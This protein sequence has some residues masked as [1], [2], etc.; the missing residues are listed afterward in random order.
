MQD[1]KDTKPKKTQRWT[2]AHPS[3]LPIQ[4]MNLLQTFFV[5]F[6]FKYLEFFLKRIKTFLLLILKKRRRWTHTGSHRPRVSGCRMETL[7]CCIVRSLGTYRLGESLPSGRT[8]KHR[9][10]WN[11]TFCE[12]PH[13]RTSPA[14][15]QFLSSRYKAVVS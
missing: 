5:S 10:S 9:G 13:R 14:R 7:S 8:A 4:Y 11:N 1:V 3:P 6:S 2:E 12:W 15:V